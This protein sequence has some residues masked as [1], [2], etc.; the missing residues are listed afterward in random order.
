MNRSTLNIGIPLG[1]RYS[2]LPKQKNKRLNTVKKRNWGLFLILMFLVVIGL[3]SF[4]GTVTAHSPD[5][6]DLFYEKSSSVLYVTITHEVSDNTS[7]Y[8]A[9]IKICLEESTIKNVNYTSQPTNDTFT[10][11]YSVVAQTGDKIKVA[12]YCNN[13]GEI[14]EDLVVGS[15]QSSLDI[16]GYAN[17]GFVLLLSITVLVGITVRRIK[18]NR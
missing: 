2:L 11:H 13:E 8:I 7:H 9:G 18:K 10:Y 4:S 16:P 3:T 1:H 6:M 14:H 5:D 12:A 17:I 15:V